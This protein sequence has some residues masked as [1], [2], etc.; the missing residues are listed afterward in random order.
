VAVYPESGVCGWDDVVML[1]EVLER[2]GFENEALVANFRLHQKAGF[3]R[4][5][6][7]WNTV[8]AEAVAG[9]ARLDQ[10]NYLFRDEAATQAAVGA[11]QGW[12][13][14][15][16]HFLYVHLMSPH[17]PLEPSPAALEALRIPRD[18]TPGGQIGVDEVTR[19]NDA[20]AKV[21]PERFRMGYAASVWDADRSVGQILDALERSGHRDTTIVALFS[22][23]GEQIWEH[24]EYGH[25]R[26]VWEQLVH[27][28]L[29]LRVPGRA[30]ARVSG[31]AVGLVDV[32]PTLTRLLGVAERPASWQGGDLL[33]GEARLPVVSERFHETAVTRDGRVKAV[34]L[35]PSEGSR[36]MFSDLERDPTEQAPL[37]WLREG[38]PLRDGF[39]RFDA[40]TPRVERDLEAAPAGVCRSVTAG[41][42]EELVE[43][44]RALGYAE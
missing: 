31:H 19:L 20:G 32:A 18:W 22:D 26:G 40:D 5:F 6:A 39:A 43:Q 8:A 1:A 27:V 30:P 36:W 23:H 35:P 24:G 25:G 42:R 16:R 14:G 15:A 34:R 29:I 28:P 12:D 7:R 3:A 44:L 37:P 4:G 13:Q 21:A 33:D 11:V 17:L 2:A 38:A 10:H 41:E 9:F